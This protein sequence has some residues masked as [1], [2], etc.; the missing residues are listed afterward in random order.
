MT[1]L[2]K[3]HNFTGQSL[4][5]YSSTFRMGHSGNGTYFLVRDRRAFMLISAAALLSVFN[6]SRLKLL[7]CCSGTCFEALGKSASRN[8]SKELA[9]SSEPFFVLLRQS[10]SRQTWV[11]VDWLSWWSTSTGARGISGK[12]WPSI[13]T[14]FSLLKWSK[15][16]CASVAL[17]QLYGFA[18]STTILSCWA[19][20]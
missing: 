14:T 15:S 7:L 17:E 11:R 12:H 20:S 6:T 8:I 1:S 16:N 13:T 10:T 9:A 2:C 18:W 5:S 4:S 3:C 19:W